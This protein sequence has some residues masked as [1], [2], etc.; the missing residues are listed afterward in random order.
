MRVFLGMQTQ[1]IVS[2]VAG[3]GYRARTYEGLN[4]P[5]LREV[6]QGLGVRLKD[7]PE[8]F[9]GLQVMELAARAVLN[10]RK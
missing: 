1:W 6:W 8:I 5:A 9:Q 7:R 2:E 10:E 4:Y 3:L